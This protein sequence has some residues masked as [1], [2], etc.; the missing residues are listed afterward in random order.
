MTRFKTKDFGFSNPS[1][2]K[3]TY[4][5]NKKKISQQ[6]V[7]LFGIIILKCLNIKNFQ[8]HCKRKHSLKNNKVGKRSINKTLALILKKAIWNMILF[9]LIYLFVFKLR[10][11]L[12]KNL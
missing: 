8:I 11:E 2:L 4:V 5:N 6:E 12:N 9:S 1:C 10:I 7:F 3:E